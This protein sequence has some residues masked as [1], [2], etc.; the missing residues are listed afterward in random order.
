MPDLS[1]KRN[2]YKK[3][4]DEA[5]SL[6]EINPQDQIEI[7]VAQSQFEKEPLKY[8]TRSEKID[9]QDAPKRDFLDVLRNR[10]SSS[11]ILSPLPIPD[12]VILKLLRLTYGYKDIN[13]NASTRFSPAAGSIY[14]FRFFAHNLKDNLLKEFDPLKGDWAEPGFPLTR[15]QL[16]KSFLISEKGSIEN[17][18]SVI[19]VLAQPER[20]YS[21]YQKLANR[22][23]FQDLGHALQNAWL[24]AE[25]FG[26]DFKISSGALDKEILQVIPYKNLM[27]LN[28]FCLNGTKF[29]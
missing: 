4:A 7:S 19:L 17:S 20:L 12:L 23:L 28:T 5:R 26:L 1:D 25:L 9:F 11:I 21:K 15:T 10:K 8:P 16:Q 14:P 24:A 18:Y 2:L 6:F 29:E 3:W 22:L 13:Q 27:Y